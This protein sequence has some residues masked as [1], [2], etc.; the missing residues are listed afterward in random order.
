MFWDRWFRRVFEDIESEIE[1]IEE[2]F[3]RAFGSLREGTRGPLVYGFSIT[4][5]PDGMPVIRRFGNLRPPTSAEEGFRTPFVDVMVDDKANEV[6]VI[7]EIPGVSKEDVKIRSTEKRV[8]ISAERGD[9]KYRAEVDL[10]VEVD[11]NS[12]RAKYNNG[13]LEITFRPK[14]ELKP[15]GTEIKVE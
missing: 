7:A 12:G 6:K 4:V 13:V 8:E 14:E 1:R 9:R 11:V 15:E 5:G 3:E 10:P 2:E